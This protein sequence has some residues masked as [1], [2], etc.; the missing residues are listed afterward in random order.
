[1]SRF[2]TLPHHVILAV[3]HI[4]S[5]MLEDDV[6]PKTCTPKP[7]PFPII[8]FVV[9]T[10]AL[11]ACSLPTPTPR[12]IPT[13]FVPTAGLTPEPTESPPETAPTEPAPVASPVPP[14]CPAP[15]SPT[16][17]QPADFADY[18]AAIQQYLSAGGGV[19]TL[20]TTL[21]GWNVLPDDTGQVAASD[22]TGDGNSEVVVAL[23]DSGA[24]MVFPAGDLLIFG[25]QAGAYVL[26][27]QEGYDP[28]GPTVRLFQISDGNMDGR[29]D[30]VYTL[31]TC[32]AHT[33]FET[34]EIVGW[35]GA[36]FASLMGGVLDMPYPTYTVTPGRI[37][38]QSSGIGSVGAEPQRDYT[39]IWEWNGS[40]FTVTQQIWAPPVYRYHALLDGDDALLSGDYATA[41]ATY[42]RVISDGTL[43]EWGAVSGVVDPAEELAQLAAFARWRLLLTRLLAGDPAG[44][45]L[46]YNRLQADHPAGAV[47]HDV[48]VLAEAFWTA[49]LMDSHVAD[50][51]AQVIA[52]AGTDTS[53]QDFFNANYGYANPWWEPV[54]LCPFTE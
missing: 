12:P 4:E 29:P 11:L 41:L 28:Y 40:V 37:E 13:V 45:Q 32:G 48:A 3:L 14:I 5:L 19:A 36:G 6:K 27:Y 35:G 46:E 17:V 7:R 33:C 23:I 54:D 53:V 49:Y 50:G 22:L 52:A 44:A 24:A 51:C 25:C 42:E 34:L 8:A 9:L 1:M 31:S 2:D 16:L 21:A 10:L 30:V 15:G 26:Q 20:E 18:P 43:Q 39:E 38:A 47:G